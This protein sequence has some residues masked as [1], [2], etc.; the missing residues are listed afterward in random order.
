MSGERETAM[1]KTILIAEDNPLHMRLLEMT[2][3]AT[4]Y[5]LIKA[6]NGAEALD[7]AARDK[8]DLIMM[9]IHLPKL[10]GF[11]VARKL[12]EHPSCRHIPIIALTAY[13]TS[14]DRERVIES[15]C[16]LYFSKPINTRELPDVVANL[17]KEQQDGRDNREENPDSR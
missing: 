2:L 12:R 4:G 3:R 14:Q 9:D 15:G 5:R 1:K 8:P 11:E 17:L 13:A 10:N 16:N 7:M 6:T